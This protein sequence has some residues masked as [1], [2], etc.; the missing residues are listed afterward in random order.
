MWNTVNLCYSQAMNDP[1]EPLDNSQHE[2]FA[3]HWAKGKNLTEAALAA[4]YK[5]SRARNT[6]ADLGAKR[7]IRERKKWLQS[8]AADE[9]VMDI[10]EKRRFCARVVR[11]RVA[12]EPPDSDLWQSIKATE[13]GT[14]YRLPDKRGM[15]ET[16]NDL[17][18]EGSEAEANQAVVTLADELALIRAR[19]RQP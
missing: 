19:R 18:G 8:Q 9:T 12:N 16:D 6:G 17:A 1:A 7:G 2:E 14:E 15:I 3:K 4:G 5:A 13:N 11:C 10:R